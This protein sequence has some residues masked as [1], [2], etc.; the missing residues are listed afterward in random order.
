MSARDP[1]Q[2]ILVLADGRDPQHQLSCFRE[3]VA[4][5]LIRGG[6]YMVMIAGHLNRT[7][8]A[9]AA[10]PPEGD[11]Q[12]LAVLLETKPD[13]DFGPRNV[14]ELLASLAP[15]VPVYQILLEGNTC[16]LQECDQ[17]TAKLKPRRMVVCRTDELVG[18][19]EE[20][21]DIAPWP[22]TT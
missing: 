3:G 17:Q 7:I 5:W 4:H 12:F 11:H 14:W 22:E 9:L 18:Q 15:D 8:Q 13:L 2:P 16:V 20:L 10:D 6:D 19:L 1:R 21:I